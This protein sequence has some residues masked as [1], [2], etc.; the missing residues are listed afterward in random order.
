MRLRA[1]LAASLV[2]I[3]PIIALHAQVNAGGSAPAWA[4]AWNGHR[5]AELALAQV[6][7]S[8]FG[9]GR[10]SLAI[11]D[12]AAE[13]AK[14]AYAK[15]PLAANAH[16]VLAMTNESRRE[17]LLLASRSLSKRE[18]L[19]G[20]MLVQMFAQEGK[21]GKLFPLLDQLSRTE[22]PLADQLVGILSASL[23][24]PDAVP[25]IREALTR[26][27]VWSPAFWRGVPSERDAL[28]AF[29]LLRSELDPQLD[30]QANRNLLAR[31]VAANRYAEAFA[32]YKAIPSVTSA[33]KGEFTTDYPPVDWQLSNSRDAQ[34]RLTGTGSVEVFV[35]QNAAGELARKLIA[36]ERGELS[37]ESEMLV[38]QGSGDIIAHLQCIT[39]GNS[40]SI[41]ASLTQTKNWQFS[42]P[43]CEYAWLTLKGS[44][45]DSSL[46]FEAT[47]KRLHLKGPR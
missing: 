12:L 19:N 4:N 1:I 16:F 33:P 11:D 47:I 43:E 34:A 23:S 7:A 44:A 6:Q 27:P 46:P 9:D 14:L 37:L 3:A 18:R 36:L 15:E 5:V 2:A 8:Q 28:D 38:R 32:V 42:A 10:L 29:L 30:E 39:G 31:L 26:E 45:W 41:S 13:T 22:P 20:L 21:V 24:D 35:D 17:A 40:E 25:L